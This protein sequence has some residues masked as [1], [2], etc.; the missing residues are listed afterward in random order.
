MPKISSTRQRLR[1]GAINA[2]T[3]SSWEFRL[4]H[5]ARGE[6]PKPE[7]ITA[8]VED[9]EQ[10]RNQLEEAHAHV[11]ELVSMV[12]IARAEAIVKYERE[13]L[14]IARDPT[15]AVQLIG[16][17]VSYTQDMWSD[18]PCHATY[19][20]EDTLVYGE[21]CGCDEMERSWAFSPE[22]YDSD[23]PRWRL[24]GTL[25]YFCWHCYEQVERGERLEIKFPYP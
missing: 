4:K 24:R 20:D 15:V 17:W 25:M 3:S 13:T 8:D 16:N 11:E 14:N 10:L 9:W 12:M 2:L 22:K 18:E 1:A 5:A 21:C 23:E 7:D 6:L 19:V